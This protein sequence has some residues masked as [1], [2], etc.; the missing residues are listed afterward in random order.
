MERKYIRTAK[1]EDASRIA[2]IEIFNYRLYFYPIFQSDAFYF[3]E[4]QVLPAAQ[5]LMA[6]TDTLTRT[7]VYDD[8][9]VKG[10]LRV[11]GSEVE[12]LFVEPALHGKHIGEALLMHAIEVYDVSWLWALEKNTGAIRFYERHG[13]RKTDIRKPEEDTEEYLVRMER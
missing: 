6:D 12:K 4:L 13:F 9:V 5:A 10:F 3:D 7:L 1:A 11:N 8:G 2:E